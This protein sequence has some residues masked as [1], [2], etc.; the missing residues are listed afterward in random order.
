M[1]RVA[2]S[3][4]VLSLLLA[5][6]SVV[7]APPSV[8]ADP[9]LTSAIAAAWLLRYED[10]DLHAIAHE[11]VETLAACDCLTHEGMAPGTAEVIAYNINVADPI[12]SVVRQWSTSAPHDAILANRSYGRIGCAELVTG[13]THWF[14]CVLAAGELPPQPA[15]AA[16]PAP[17]PPPQGGFL[18]PDTALPGPGD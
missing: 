12:A 13:S 2:V 4:F 14:A 1:R 15:P 10:A 17:P 7:P 3:L 5:V 9:G 6:S 8:R 11:R 16:V 18:L